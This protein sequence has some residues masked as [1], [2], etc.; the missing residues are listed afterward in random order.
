MADLSPV[1]CMPRQRTLGRRS[2][3]RRGLG[4]AVLLAAARPLRAQRLPRV[5]YLNP[6]E[7]VSRASGAH[8]PLTSRFM[9]LAANAL[10]FELE[11]LY[12]DR[13]HL[14]MLRQAEQVAQRSPAPDYLVAV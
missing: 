9:S 12:A 2:L 1:S 5:V 3:I 11:V 13:D 4:A 10:G 7:P 14:L 6:G 8:W